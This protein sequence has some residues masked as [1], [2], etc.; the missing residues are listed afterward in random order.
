MPTWAGGAA[1]ELWAKL[2]WQSE[3]QSEHLIGTPPHAGGEEVRGLLHATMRSGS[4][5]FCT[6]LGDTENC[7]KLDLPKQT[8]THILGVPTVN[9]K[10]RKLPLGRGDVRIRHDPPRRGYHQVSRTFLSHA[11]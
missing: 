5:V 9:A 11:L 7:D 3:A 8:E 4:V 1:I 2:A 6:L 10:V